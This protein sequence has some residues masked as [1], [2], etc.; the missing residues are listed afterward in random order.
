MCAYTFYIF[1][2]LKLKNYVSEHECAEK[3]RK[4]SKGR[5]RCISKSLEQSR[6]EIMS[7]P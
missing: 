7:G 1:V 6:G 2:R 5:D 4:R 3:S